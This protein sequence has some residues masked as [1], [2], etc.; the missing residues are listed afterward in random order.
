MVDELAHEGEDAGVVGGGGQNQLVVAEGVLHGLG[1]VA[2]GQIVDGD[3]RAALFAQHVGQR[4]HGLLRVA[5]D[6]GVGDD[7]AVALRRVGRP[8]VVQADVLAEVF[9]EDGAVQRADDG[10][11]QPGGLFEKRLHLRA[12][13]AD[14][15]DVVAA[16]LAGPFL[17]HIQRAE[18]AKAVGGEEDFI[19]AVVS[20]HDLRPVYH[21]R[22]DEGKGVAAGGQ[23]VAVLDHEAVF[24]G[25]AE[26]LLHHR[27]RLGV[28][29]HG[30]VRVGLDEI[31]DVGGVIRLHVLHDE[32]VRLAAVQRRLDIVQPLV[33]EV[34]V[35]G[36]EH[37]DLFVQHD[38]G[39]VAH[40]V[41][42]DVLAL[43]QIDGM[44]VH[45]DIDDVFGYIVHAGTS[46]AFSSIN[47]ILYRRGN[48]HART[49][50]FPA[51]SAT[52]GRRYAKEYSRRGC[53]FFDLVL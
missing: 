44:V 38:V 43:K 16:G 34:L 20:D 26:E 42:H 39:I 14:D 30:D 51:L 1:H 11:V 9:R 49:E 18:L 3:R 35:H 2:A 45:A 31:V 15:A 6:R 47:S 25:A 37:A 52:C 7:D 13:L 50:I 4:L 17:L 28:A 24:I 46:L 19:G 40:A 21:G 41:G 53:I 22:E 33:G 27:K 10:D 36:V 12:V 8:Q 32:V 23:R 48:V 5:V 29:H